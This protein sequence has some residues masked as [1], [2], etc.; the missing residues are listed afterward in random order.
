MNES[1]SLI[2]TITKF[3]FIVYNV[4][5]NFQLLE[6]TKSDVSLPIMLVGHRLKI[7]NI[8]YEIIQVEHNFI[9]KSNRGVFLTVYYA[10]QAD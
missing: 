9:D 8:K 3:K 10:M 5:D 2:T 4:E 7:N 6:S 1:I